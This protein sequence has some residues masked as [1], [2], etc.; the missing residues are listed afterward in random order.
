MEILTDN[1]GRIARLKTSIDTLN[2]ITKAID[3]IKFETGL[4]YCDD[5]SKVLKKANEKLDELKK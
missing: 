3:N 4:N 2:F 1:L 5:P